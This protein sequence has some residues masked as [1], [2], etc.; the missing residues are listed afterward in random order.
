MKVIKDIRPIVGRRE[1]QIKKICEAFAK[2]KS[3]SWT[4]VYTALKRAKCDDLA[5]YVEASFL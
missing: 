4:K 5:D 1:D 3:S 2:E